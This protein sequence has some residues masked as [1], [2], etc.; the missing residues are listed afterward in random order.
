MTP[1]DLDLRRGRV[2]AA[3]GH[4]VAAG[5]AQRSVVRD[6]LTPRDQDGNVGP[7][8]QRRSRRQR[9]ARGKDVAQVRR[10][11]AD[12]VEVECTA[13]VAGTAVDIDL[14]EALVPAQVLH[15]AVRHEVGKLKLSPVRS[16][17]FITL[18]L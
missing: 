15:V 16:P 2:Y 1:F 12:L 6:R 14:L 11:G 13:G 18:L 5:E 7:D 9:E 4:G 10:V 8:A 3:E 17:L